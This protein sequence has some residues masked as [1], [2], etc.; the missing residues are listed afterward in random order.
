M[1]L[2]READNSQVRGVLLPLSKGVINRW[3]IVTN[4]SAQGKCTES[5]TF[6][7]H[8]N[9]RQGVCTGN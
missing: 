4:R 1:G 3:V 8:N 6:Q 9:K 2:R 7:M 5:H